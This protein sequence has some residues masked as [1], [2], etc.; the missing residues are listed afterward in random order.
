VWLGQDGFEDLIARIWAGLWPDARCRFSFRTAFKPDDADRRDTLLFSTPI[1]QAG[2]WTGYPIVRTDA[3]HAELTP[4]EALLA[5]APSPLRDRIVEFSLAGKDL[6]L[7]RQIES[8]DVDLRALGALGPSETR[9]LLRRVGSVAEDPAAARSAKELVLD[10]LVADVSGEDAS[11][12]HTLRNIDPSPFG[13]G[14]QALENAIAQWICGNA[15][16]APAEVASWLCHTEVDALGWWRRAVRTGVRRRLE[17]NAPTTARLVWALWRAE[18]RIVAEVAQMPEVRALVDGLVEE[19][20]PKLP[21]GVAD[22]VLD[23][24]QAMRW[25]PL[26]AAVAVSVY[27]LSRALDLLLEAFP[28]A[29]DTGLEIIG[30][31]VSPR[32]IARAVV[33]RGDSLFDL[34]AATFIAAM[35]DVRVELDPGTEHGRALWLSS[36]EAGAPVWAGIEDVGAWLDTVLAALMHGDPFAKR[37]VGYIAPTPAADLSSTRWWDRIWNVLPPDAVGG[38]AEASVSGWLTRFRCDPQN[39]PLPAAPLRARILAD[40]RLLRAGASSTSIDLAAG[41][42]AIHRFELGEATLVTWVRENASLLHHLR[43]TDAERLGALIASRRWRGAANEIDRHRSHAPVLCA[44]VHPCRG[45]QPLLSRIRFEFECVDARSPSSDDWYAALHQF[46]ARELPRGPE[47][48]NV[49]ERAGGTLSRIRGG[50]AGEQWWSAV[51]EIKR[52]RGG[53]NLSP[54]RLLD[55]LA[56]DFPRNPDL[57]LLRRTAPNG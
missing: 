2:R 47:Q 7:L 33:A 25:V 14:F 49:W 12:V 51:N 43:A 57:D 38:F 17:D 27:P 31:R 46:L 53:R 56:S 50:N 20:P 37:L 24:A 42:T 6:R 35:P 32:D 26:H 40:P 21:A 54:G 48:D 16:D 23:A 45:L 22:A 28:A 13:I 18:P 19:T 39:V 4:A 30:R 3:F 29:L 1:L 9:M 41:L 55:V 10:R 5:G 34:W 44:A 52:G 36:V 11:F 8:I 15:S